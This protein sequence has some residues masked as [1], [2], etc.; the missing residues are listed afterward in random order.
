MA[1][2]FPKPDKFPDLPRDVIANNPVLKLAAKRHAELFVAPKGE[3]VSDRDYRI[4]QANTIVRDVLL[5]SAD[6]MAMGWLALYRH[7]QGECE[8]AMGPGSLMQDGRSAKSA[9]RANVASNK[10]DVVY[11]GFDIFNLWD[12]GRD[13]AV[14]HA[15]KVLAYYRA[16]KRFLALVMP[17]AAL[18]P[19]PTPVVAP[20][21]VP[22]PVPAVVPV[23]VPVPAAPLVV[24]LGPILQDAHADAQADAEVAGLSEREERL[25]EHAAYLKQKA[26]EQ[27]LGPDESSDEDDSDE[28]EGGEGE[29]EENPKRSPSIPSITPPVP[30]HDE[31]DREVDEDFLNAFKPR[32][33]EPT[34]VSSAAPV[35]GDEEGEETS[36]EATPVPVPGPATTITATKRRVVAAPSSS[37]SLGASSSKPMEVDDES[38]EDSEKESSE[39]E[40]EEGDDESVSSEEV[41]EIPPPKGK[42]KAKQATKAKSTVTARTTGRGVKAGS[43]VRKPAPKAKVSKP[44][45]TAGTS[46]VSQEVRRIVHALGAYLL[47]LAETHP[48]EAKQLALNVHRTTRLVA[49]AASKAK[50]LGQLL[51]KFTDVIYDHAKPFVPDE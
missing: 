11:R 27:G 15:L 37:S 17:P 19:P 28:E 36:R 49:A 3:S 43:Q 45:K 6:E 33:G 29:E 30:Q 12:D 44:T 20:V 32:G 23:P 41:A 22:V 39:K 2:R 5:L 4:Q 35:G 8:K 48:K 31:E 9:Y 51:D 42:G 38:E 10:N 34:T 1:E 7:L 26:E 13:E 14:E 46:K 47:T 50:P 16:A 25:R 40:E 24:P 18:A 21:A